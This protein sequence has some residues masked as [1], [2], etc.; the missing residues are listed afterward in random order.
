MEVLAREVCDEGSARGQHPGVQLSAIPPLLVHICGYHHLLVAAEDGEG[1]GKGMESHGV[2]VMGSFGD[3]TRR[4]PSLQSAGVGAGAVRHAAAGTVISGQAAFIVQTDRGPA[5]PYSARQVALMA[6]S[7][8]Q[9][10]AQV[11]IRSTQD[12][13]DMYFAADLEPQIV[14]EFKRRSPPG[15]A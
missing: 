5:G 12:P 15:P 1:L 2:P 8:G 13:E 9:S 10:L 6:I 3:L 4:G 11:Q 7:K 14:Q